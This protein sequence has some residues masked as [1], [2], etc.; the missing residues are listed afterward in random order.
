MVS[1]ILSILIQY[2]CVYSV[3][4]GPFAACEVLRFARA[5]L[6]KTSGEKDTRQQQ[7]I[8]KHYAKMFHFVTQLNTSVEIEL[9]MSECHWKQ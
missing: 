8:I 9:D 1:K 7:N 2:L 3:S 5:S 6:D 4:G